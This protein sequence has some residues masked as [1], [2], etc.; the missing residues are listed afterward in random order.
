ML[1]KWLVTSPRQVRR[2]TFHSKEHHG[3]RNV[4]VR[5]PTP[6]PNTGFEG[7]PAFREIVARSWGRD[8]VA[9]SSLVM[10]DG[11]LDRKALGALVFDHPPSRR[12]LNRSAAPVPLECY[13]SSLKNLIARA[14]AHTHAAQRCL[15]Q[16]SSSTASHTHELAPK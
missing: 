5:T 15:C 4:H 6:L 10:S 14:L 13:N 7:M 9:G 2:V 16:H 12:V 3:Y 1:T 8:A 11:Q